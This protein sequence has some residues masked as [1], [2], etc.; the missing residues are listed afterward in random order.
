MIT[1]IATA[2]LGALIAG[3]PNFIFP[4][5][6]H[7]R[8]AVMECAYTAKMEYGIGVMIVFLAILLALVESWEVRIGI[9][10][11]MGFTGILAAVAATF[12]MGFCD[13][14]CSIECTCNPIT[15]PLMTGIGILIAVIAF[16]NAIY[17][18]RKKHIRRNM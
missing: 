12:L 3:I 2:I 14:N 5:G 10:I 16:V 18:S 9:S 13:G 1:G 6:E 17:L 7:C 4:V 11:G 8:T 15:S